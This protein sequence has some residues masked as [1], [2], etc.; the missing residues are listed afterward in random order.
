MNFKILSVVVGTEA[1]IA[2]CPFCVSGVK[3]CE[4]NLKA[5]EVNWRNLKIAGNLANRSKVDTVMLTSRGEPTLFPDQIT[6]Y[7][8]HLKE[9]NFPFIELQTNGILIAKK[10]D[11]YRTYL[12][13]W[14]ENGLTTITLSVVSYRPEINKKVYTPNGEYIDLPDLIQF[15]HSFGFSLRLTCVCCKGFTDTREEILNFIDFAK[16]NKVEQV[17][18]RPVNDEF[19]RESAKIWVQNNKLEESDKKLIKLLLEEKG[20]KLLELDRIGTVY[21]V[22]GQNV[23][24]SLP[25]NKNTRDVDPENGRQLIFFPDGHIRYEW[26]MTGGILL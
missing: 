11:Y 23:C 7:L 19:R 13:E 5:P 9:F 15:L 18:L 6:E 16:F 24:L 1:C 25:L 8:K 26:E 21:D 2:S 3:P 20:T 10:K 22:F 17:T 4:D 14:Y 12:K